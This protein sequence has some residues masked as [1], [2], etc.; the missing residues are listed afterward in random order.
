MCI[1]TTKNMDDLKLCGVFQED[2]WT[3]LSGDLK[4]GGCL[5]NVTTMPSVFYLTELFFSSFLHD[6]GALFTDLVMVITAQ[7]P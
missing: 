7:Q 2:G 1:I 5:I 3:V 4:E 6:C